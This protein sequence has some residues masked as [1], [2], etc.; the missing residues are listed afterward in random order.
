MN[1]PALIDSNS[2]IDLTLRSKKYIQPTGNSPPP[3]I[4][5]PKSET[6]LVF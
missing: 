3:R 6:K 4:Y 5:S 1:K 2:A